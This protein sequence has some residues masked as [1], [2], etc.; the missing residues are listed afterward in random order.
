MISRIERD[1]ADTERQPFSFSRFLKPALD[2][3]LWAY[4]FIFGF[5]KM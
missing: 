5:V 1:R 3:K 4:A 2:L